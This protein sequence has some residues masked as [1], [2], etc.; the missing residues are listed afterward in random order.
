MKLASFDLNLLHKSKAIGPG[1]AVLAT[2]N[3]LSPMTV[4][5]EGVS[6]GSGLSK[7]NPKEAPF[8]HP[9]SRLSNDCLQQYQNGEDLSKLTPIKRAQMLQSR[10][11]GSLN[12][13]SAQIGKLSDSFQIGSR[14]AQRKGASSFCLRMQAMK[15]KL[16]SRENSFEVIGHNS[17]D[18]GSLEDEAAVDESLQARDRETLSRIRRC[19]KQVL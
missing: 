2:G 16:R 17:S 6:S 15:D 3:E 19:S 14:P 10:A 18:A 9:G 8:G 13:Q 11:S 5:T 12:A 4:D 1:F 7:Q